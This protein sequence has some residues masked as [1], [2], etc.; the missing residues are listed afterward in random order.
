[1]T[2]IIGLLAVVSVAALPTLVLWIIVQWMRRVSS[3]R[4]TL[5]KFKVFVW[6]RL[7]EG[8]VW[9]DRLRGLED[10]EAAVDLNYIIDGIPK[11]CQYI[12]PVKVTL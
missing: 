5:E 12:E 9:D 2:T 6:K 7:D 10:A 4:P 8:W 3:Q 11:T 1:M